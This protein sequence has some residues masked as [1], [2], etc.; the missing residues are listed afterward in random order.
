[1]FNVE[2]ELLTSGLKT[3]EEVVEFM[4]KKVESHPQSL[5]LR[6][7]LSDA[8][9]TAGEYKAGIQVC[10]G[11][12]R[13]EA[14]QSNHSFRFRVVN[15]LAECAD[16][17]GDFERAQVAYREALEI[18]PYDA[19][20]A[21]RYGFL[22]LGM[23]ELAPNGKVRGQHLEAAE[24]VFADALSNTQD[25]VELYY[26]RGLALMRARRLEEAVADLEAG[27]KVDGTY[28]PIHHKLGECFQHLQR[29]PEAIEAYD[30]FVGGHHTYYQTFA[31]HDEGTV[32]SAYILAD[33]LMRRARCYMEA[34]QLEFAAF[35][36]DAIL[37]LQVG[38]FTGIA[39]H[40]R[41]AIALRQGRHQDCIDD[42]TKALSL[43]GTILPALQDRAAAYQSLDMISQAQEDLALI[44][45][46]LSKH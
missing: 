6:D 39:Y 43:C 45:I 4:L 36:V 32:P 35:D 13:E 44:K 8:H 27:L 33:V 41:G 30:A 18:D 42:N 20:V 38:T 1:M 3:S 12:L 46:L 24:K 19:N 25:D 28:I 9:L 37:K 14:L 16:R 11:L 10:E 29:Y 22:L 2:N 31:S 23:S 7:L 34:G 15:R 40:L 26:G 21:R 17:M 5:E